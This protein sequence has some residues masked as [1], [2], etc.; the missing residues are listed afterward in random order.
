VTV[1]DTG[2]AARAGFVV[3]MLVGPFTVEVTAFV[4]PN[5]TVAPV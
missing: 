5:F 1:I 2:P 3:V 4:S